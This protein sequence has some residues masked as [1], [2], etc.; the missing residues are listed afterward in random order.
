MSTTTTSRRRGRGGLV[1]V[2]ALTLLVTAACGSS[3]S[4][5]DDGGGSSAGGEAKIFVIGGKSDDSFWSKVKRGVDDAAVVVEKNGGSVT[6]L[7]PK[8]YDNLGPD[9]AK[10]IESAVSQNATAIIAP[11]WVPDAQDAAL[12]NVVSKDIP[13]WIYNSGGIEAAD[14]VGAVNYVGT[15]EVVAGKAGG[16]FLGEEGLKNVLCI[17]T[18][19]GTANVDARCDGIAD[20]IES[21][22]GSSKQLSLPSSQFGDKT[23]VAQAIKAA[24]LKDKDIDAVVTIGVVDADSAVSALEQAD[25]RDKVKLGTFDT[26][27]T[28]LNLVKDGTLMFAIDQQ[29]YMQGYLAVSMASSYVKYGL[30]MP[31]RPILTGP[32]IIEKDNVAAA[33]AGAK[34]G[35]R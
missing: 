13:L 14:E 27:D 28:T 4:G 32:A 34:A 33:L 18:L 9:A 15:D 17:N 25:L 12:K 2:A 30:D 1:A 31:Q 26:D 35:V 24:L 8:N 29:P 22:G 11:D 6:F 7:G 3:D 23:A 16:E 10:L 19:P 20:G 21:S 5:S